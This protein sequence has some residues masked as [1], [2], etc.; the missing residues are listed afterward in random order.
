MPGNGALPTPWWVEEG[1]IA[2]E[3]EF[4]VR[5]DVLLGVYLIEI[6][7]CDAKSGQR[8]PVPGSVAQEDR[9][10]LKEVVVVK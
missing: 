7:L 9:I 3:Y 10:L 2:D 1:V 8:L 4:A 5:P 6:G